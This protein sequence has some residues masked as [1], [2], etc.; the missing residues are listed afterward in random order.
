MKSDQELDDALQRIKQLEK[1]LARW[2]Q[3]AI[4]RLSPEELASNVLREQ[5]QALTYHLM[6]TSKGL[7][8]KS[9]LLSE[10]E[11]ELEAAKKTIKFLDQQL[12]NRQKIIEKLRQLITVFKSSAPIGGASE[13]SGDIYPDK[14]MQKHIMPPKREK[15]SIQDFISLIKHVERVKLMDA[16]MILDTSPKTIYSWAKLL[17]SKGYADIGGSELEKMVV[18][19]T[20]RLLNSK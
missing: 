19:A 1:D 5:T 16:S 13:E 4:E 3:G 2:E 20:K 8:Q 18:F 12:D 17:N 6:R 10:K 15:K 11:K 7:E 9:R 14:S